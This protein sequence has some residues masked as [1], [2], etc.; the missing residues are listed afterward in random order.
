MIS[1]GAEVLYLLPKFP[2]PFFAARHRQL[3]SVHC[4]HRLHPLFTAERSFHDQVSPPC[5]SLCVCVCVCVCAA[6]YERRTDSKCPVSTQFIT[7]KDECLVAAM[8]IGLTDVI[9]MDGLANTGLKA[10]PLGCFIHVKGFL[11]TVMFNAKGNANFPTDSKLVS[12]CRIAN[13]P[14][15]AGESR[16]GPVHKMSAGK[17]Q[18][19]FH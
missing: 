18:Y 8:S 14:G 3:A 7:S 17:Y 19:N 16:P 1:N 15:P 4:Y 5:P 13:Y 6:L 2:D 10:S 9:L 12:L 11:Q